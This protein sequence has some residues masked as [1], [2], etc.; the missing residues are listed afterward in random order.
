MKTPV[1]L[2]SGNH[3]RKAWFY[4]FLY[5]LFQTTESFF[6]M[7]ELLK[8][9]STVRIMW[10]NCLLSRIYRHV[11]LFW[12]S[13]LLISTKRDLFLF[14]CNTN[15]VPTESSHLW[16]VC[17]YAYVCEVW[18]CV[19]TYMSDWQYLLIIISSMFL[20]ICWVSLYFNLLG[21]FKTN[22][23]DAILTAY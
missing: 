22:M 9:I 14:L 11:C 1:L 3:F 10:P 23:T 2:Y 5:L 6:I 17:C 19:C 13:W 21:Y 18:V 15:F 16:H 20:C 7:T 8:L 4:Y 12:E